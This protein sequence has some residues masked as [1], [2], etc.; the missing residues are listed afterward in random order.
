MEE[1]SRRL[2]WVG[3]IGRPSVHPYRVFVQG[4][5]KHILEEVC[6]RIGPGEFPLALEAYSDTR[7]DDGFHT[8]HLSEAKYYLACLEELV[9]AGGQHTLLDVGQAMIDPLPE[10][11]QERYERLEHGIAQSVLP[12]PAPA[13]LHLLLQRAGFECSYPGEGGAW[14]S[15]YYL[16]PEDAPWYTLRYRIAGARNDFRAFAIMNEVLCAYALSLL[17]VGLTVLHRA[18]KSTL[19]RKSSYG[20]F[21]PAWL[22]DD[23][24]PRLLIGTAASIVTLDD[25]DGYV[26]TRLKYTAPMS[27]EWHAY[28]F[29]AHEC[30]QALERGDLSSVLHASLSR[31]KCDAEASA[32][33]GGEERAYWTRSVWAYEDVLARLALLITQEEYWWKHAALIG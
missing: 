33:Q 6:A 9:C 21:R 32:A 19:V 11:E 30:I 23:A 20:V 28:T 8:E 27:G 10:G 26:Q 3:E 4:W 24:G 25:L 2:A 31:S 7:G 15:G 17:Q 13:H 1:L 22:V 16:T 12:L 18:A 29:A 14:S 5:A